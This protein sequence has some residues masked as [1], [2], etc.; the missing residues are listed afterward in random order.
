MPFFLSFPCFF[1]WAHDLNESWRGK[2]NNKKIR[3]QGHTENMYSEQLMDLVVFFWMHSSVDITNQN[4][5]CMWSLILK[6]FSNRRKANLGKH[7]KR[8]H[9]QKRTLMPRHSGTLI[10]PCGTL[11]SPCGTLISPCGTLISPCGT[12]ISPR[13]RRILRIDSSC[14]HRHL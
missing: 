13:E 12:L 4:R 11:I 3:F 10:S 14:G 7:G 9:F 5:A 8:R 6:C 2:K 1:N